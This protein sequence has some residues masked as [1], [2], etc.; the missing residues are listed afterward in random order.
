MNVQSSL[1][2]ELMLYEFELRNNITEA[3]KNIC[4][5]ECEGAVDYST[6]TRGFKEFWSSCKNPNDQVRYA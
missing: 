1:I 6:V 5:A 4:W 2:Q 3:T